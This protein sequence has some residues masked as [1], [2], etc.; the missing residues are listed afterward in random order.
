MGQDKMK[1]STIAANKLWKLN[2]NELWIFF[3]PFQ[4]DKV[5]VI[6][7][8]ADSNL[9]NRWNIGQTDPTPWWSQETKSY[10]S[11][12]GISYV[13]R[14]EGVVPVYELLCTCPH[15]QADFHYSR[16][17]HTIVIN[18]HTKMPTTIRVFVQINNAIEKTKWEFSKTKAKE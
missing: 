2:N 6:L 14:T 18:A 4:R 5:N 11:L 1:C 8:H 16:L 9:S 12:A 17:T 3:S 15:V 13:V 7:W 10:W